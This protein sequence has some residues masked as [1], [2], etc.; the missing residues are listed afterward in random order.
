MSTATP[1]QSE[2]LPKL[3]PSLDGACHITAV[4]RRRDGRTRFWCLAHKA[5]ATGKYGRK[6][7]V[8]RGA[9]VEPISEKETLAL[10]LDQ[11]AGGVALWGAV[12]PVYDTT[13]LPLDRGIHVHAR[14]NPGGD[15][16]HDATFRAGKVTGG[17]LPPGGLMI[18]E[19]DAVYYMVSSIFGFG[20]R[21]IVR[22]SALGQGL[23]RCSPASASLVRGMRASFSRYR[24]RDWQPYRGVAKSLRFGHA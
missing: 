20:I 24:Y 21:F 15:K 7:S 17:K 3:P 10:N 1:R 13:R 16:V 4:G 19:L 23:V 9:G 12:P 5:D 8:C 2:L 22:V 14:E 11:F 6:L 18:S